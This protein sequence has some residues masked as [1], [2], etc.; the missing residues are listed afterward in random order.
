MKDIK[1]F[2]H[3]YTK[4]TNESK[5]ATF[6]KLSTLC[7][8]PAG[9]TC[10]YHVAKN[11]QIAKEILGYPSF[12]DAAISVKENISNA[13]LVPG[14]YP[15]V[16]SF[17]MDPQLVVKEVFIEKIPALVFATKIDENLVNDKDKVIYHHPAV[18]PLL[19]ELAI[20]WTK[21][22]HASSNSQACKLL[23]ENPENSRCITN[24]ICA[25]HY[26]LKIIKILRTGIQ[27]PWLCIEK[28]RQ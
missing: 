6:D 5:L 3:Q 24:Q 28:I 20:N 9:L 26:K 7:D 10:S 23:I 21:T 13:F 18:T 16:N 14:A 22:I 8:D 27:M 2:I 19:S 11:K 25:H 12:E 17:I 1:S 15:K 4:N